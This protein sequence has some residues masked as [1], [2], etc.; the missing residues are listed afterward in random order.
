MDRGRTDEVGGR[1]GQRVMRHLRRWYVYV[2][3]TV[4]IIALLAWR[5]HLWE[6]GD[7]LRDV[8]L[9]FIAIAV[10]LN[11]VIIAA[12]AARS[13]SLLGALGHAISFRSLVPIVC[14]ANTIN[15]LTPA[16]AGEIVRAVLLNRRHEVPYRDGA[17]V[18][19]LERVYA[20]G[21]IAA[22][23]ATC[24]LGVVVGPV[25]AIA[26]IVISIAAFATPWLGY[27]RGLRFR[28]A[29]QRVGRPAI[30][31][32]RRLR[33]LADA[34]GDVEDRVA[35][36]LRSARSTVVFVALTSLVFITMDVQLWLV[37]QSIGV[38]IDPVVGWAALGLGALAGV[39]SALPFGLGAADAVIAVVLIGQGLEPST[40]ALITIL[41]RL[42]GTLPTGIVGAASYVYLNRTEAASPDATT[43]GTPDATT[44]GTPDAARE[45]PV[46]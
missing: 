9:T 12:W 1:E 11:L 36:I 28:T 13:A 32:S 35:E 7:L 37:G 39:L 2:P 16:S 21:L 29:V 5:T 17:A 23:A 44:R 40:A 6:A 8:N 15:G 24:F 46:P 45:T 25:A 4:A 14:F 3:I 10:L 38:A 26:L 30:E 31:R 27:R 33:A 41:M 43:R 42:V 20:L 22:T 19:I 18:I 34:F